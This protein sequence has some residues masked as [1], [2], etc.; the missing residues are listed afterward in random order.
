VQKRSFHHTKEQDLSK[1]RTTGQNHEWTQRGET[2][3]KKVSRLN[4]LNEL[5]G[6]FW[7]GTENAELM[8]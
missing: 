1:G 7:R 3:S 6:I 2:A 5:N 4:G 8:A